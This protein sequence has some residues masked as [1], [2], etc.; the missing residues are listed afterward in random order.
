[1]T[2]EAA[3]QQDA[4]AEALEIARGLAR[5]GIPIFIAPPSSDPKDTSGFRLPGRWQQTK[6]DPAT[7][8]HWRPGWAVCAVMGH[9][10]DLVDLDLYAGAEVDKIRGPLLA[11]R[12]YGR[13][14]TASGGI[15]VFV[16]SMGV[17]SKNGL[18]KGIDIKAGDA[19]GKGHGF[20]FI[21]PTI[22]P[23]KV[24]G[25]LSPYYWETPP[26]LSTL[27][28]TGQDTSGQALA[29]LLAP[30]VPPMPVFNGNGLNGHSVP[31]AAQDNPFQTARV[32]PWG[33]YKAEGKEHPEDIQS[34]LTGSG[35][36]NGVMRLA[37]A[38]RGQG[39]WELDKA[40]EHMYEH[41]WPLIDQGQ[42]V[43]EFPAEEFEATIRAQWR[44][45]PDG[46]LRAIEVVEE[47]AE[48]TEWP[49]PGSILELSDAYVADTV[50]R[51]CLRGKFLWARG[52]NWL[53]WTG[54]VWATVDIGIVHDHL[55]RG[56]REWY[57]I[58]ARRGA[59]PAVLA[60]MSTLLGV[61]KIRQV[62]DLVHGHPQITHEAE[63][64]DA[65]PDMVNTPEC[66]VDLRTGETW[67]NDPR[68]MLTKIT[69]GRYV[70]GC[71]H[72]DW[73]QALTALD[74]PERAWFK[75][76]VGQA[77][78]GHPPSDGIMPVLQGSGENAKTALTTD[79]PV[80][81]LGDYADMA[82]HKLISAHRPGVSE[83]STEL[84]DLRGQ[85]L[86][87][88][89]ELAE[90]RS[91]DVTAL[92]RIQDVG[93]IKAR[94]V[95]KDNITFTASH[96]LFVTTN[97]IPV[98]NETDHGTWRRLA[99]LKFRYTY[100][101]TAAEVTRPTDRLADP[102]IKQRIRQNLSGQHDAIVTWAIEAAR[103][104]YRNDFRDAPVTDQIKADTLTWRE[105]SDR[106]LGFCS[107]KLEP[108]HNACVLA[109]D[110]VDQ[111]NA[112]LGANGHNTWPKETFTPRFS[113]HDWT[114]RNGVEN[115]RTKA[116]GGLVLWPVFN[117]F[118]TQKE[119]PRQAVVWKGVRPRTQDD[120]D[121][122]DRGAE[123]AG[124]TTNLS[125]NSHMEEFAE[126]SAPP[127]PPVENPPPEGASASGT[128]PESGS[129]QSNG[130]SA[131]HV[132]TPGP[133]SAPAASPPLVTQSDE[134]GN[135]PQA[136]KPP[137]AKKSREPKPP[138]R[139]GPD[140]GLAGTL[141][142]L[143]VAVNR[144]GVVLPCT[145]EQAITLAAN[146]ELTA[147]VETTGYPIGHPDYVL[148][149]IQLG[150][151]Q[152]AVVFDAAD[153]GHQSAVR[154][155]LAD[156]VTLHAHSAVADLVPL[157]HAG[158]CGEE[159]WVKMDDTVL[160]AKL[161]DPHMS[162]S[163]ADGLKRLA[164]DVLRDYAVSPAA[165][166]AKNAL[167]ASGKWLVKTDA[168][169]PVEKSGWA[170]VDPHCETMIRYAAS[171]VLD[172]AALP[173]AL[174]PVDPA[175]LDRE[176]AVQRV[177]SVVSHRGLRL[178]RDHIRAKLD[179]HRA[180][181]DE[182]A[183]LLQANWEVSN[184]NSK[185][186]VP[187]AFTRLGV[188]L[189][190][191]KPS[192]MF[193]D[194]QES[195]ASGNLEP[196]AAGDGPGA[197]L[198]KAILGY[199]HHATAMALLLEP[200]DVLCSRGDGRVY[201]SIYTIEAGTGRMSSRRMNL[202]QFSRQGGMR[203]C[204]IADEGMMGVSADFSSVE[205]RVGAALSGDAGLKE[206]IRNA[207]AYPDRKKEFDLHWIA[208]QMVWGAEATYE[209][210]YV[211]KR[212]IFSK[213]YGGAAAAGARQTGVPEA[214][215]QAVHDAF[216]RIA[217]RFVDWSSW[218][219]Q[220]V[221]SSR[222]TYFTAYSG[223]PIWLPRNASHAAGNYAI[224]GTAREFLADGLLKW[225]QTQ[226]GGGV[227]VPIHDEIVTFAPAG[228]AAAATTQ[229]VACMANSLND[230]Q[231]VAE[232]SDPWTSWPDAS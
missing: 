173:R 74:A 108:D 87:I 103:D 175:I 71:T 189:S 66:I 191:T 31:P 224:Q 204:I 140:P 49:I 15:H 88:G 40:I 142:A 32:S 70:P 162:G 62:I 188:P 131:T 6:P 120:Q 212:I 141:Y 19:D 42:G 46:V 223:R 151:D 181:R 10:I 149:T 3:P 81:A 213:M 52:L 147:D 64:F 7:L 143:P 67:P 20:A 24:T 12:H 26:D 84:A 144:A 215:A 34:T 129:A 126:R 30:I 139:V 176:R 226:W 232:A 167:F 112:W 60:K 14:G 73:E 17:R 48:S 92:K 8:D 206:L 56:F 128:E 228:E 122:D 198:A 171:D 45:Y 44:Q 100:R 28:A 207:D 179:E 55:G 202:Q 89:E 98:I 210:R 211:A 160:H 172:T 185:L 39:G 158:L 146:D 109:T 38:L 110:M 23:S 94:Y 79:G 106:I 114:T 13:A 150:N 182:A 166:K 80:R 54:L 97:Y 35:R 197:E 93:R 136:E 50:E 138:K 133:S 72:E 5:A 41:V 111:F 163:D 190:R 218:M 161:A 119:P 186:E 180:G 96:S 37:A 165:E 145:I 153:P 132:S 65:Y 86:L 117:D 220:E 59:E 157:V 127:A 85:R 229:L 193:P 137:R 2:A 58:S 11:A 22:K 36:N 177:C 169:T 99:L 16:A 116:L 231:I 155:L 214:A 184:A 152:V 200:M 21:A 195:S 76:R 154:Q 77:I 18:F 61:S 63:D 1:M 159:I 29:A 125:K 168:L 118:Q 156:A 104:W 78:T 183:E 27:A 216:A 83:H 203:A 102:G 209:N 25:E 130:A 124:F 227:V 194:G 101:K 68:W 43:H 75:A 95:H 51:C 33:R 91:L 47:H 174:P 57:A 9:G 69:S 170:Q 82:S 219:R 196:L 107:A 205:V 53:R 105:Q 164:G 199:R 135:P 208:A 123:G 192:K 4:T 148:R 187:A 230:V 217:P 121:K 178:D 90:G 113:D 115:R 225:R 134:N 201:P 222:M 221:A